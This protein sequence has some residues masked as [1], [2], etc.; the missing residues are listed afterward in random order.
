MHSILHIMIQALTWYAEEVG[1][2]INRAVCALYMG[3][4][5]GALADARHAIA[6]LDAEEKR[7]RTCCA[8]IC[9]D[10]QS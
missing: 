8:M 4:A 9:N 10:M 1:A 5:R 6:A 2:L 3:D 7:R